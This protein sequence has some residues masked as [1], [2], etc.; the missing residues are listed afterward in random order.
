MK[1]DKVRMALF[2]KTLVHCQDLDFAIFMA[3]RLEIGSLDFVIFL[4]ANSCNVP[5]GEQKNNKSEAA[6]SGDAV[7]K[8]AKSRGS[9]LEAKI[10]G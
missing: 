8:I 5:M 6:L 1:I 3:S 2:I 9:V 7:K 10:S 4:R